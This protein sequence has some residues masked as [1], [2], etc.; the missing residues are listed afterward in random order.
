MTKA[1]F[2]E[3]LNSNKSIF[4]LLEIRDTHIRYGFDR[5]TLYIVWKGNL[6]TNVHSGMGKTDCFIVN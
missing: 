1:K 2:L 3:L 6:T 5:W 4:A